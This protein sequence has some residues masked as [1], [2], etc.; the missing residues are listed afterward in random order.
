[1]ITFF[2]CSDFQESAAKC[3][4]FHIMAVGLLAMYAVY[5][6]LGGSLFYSQFAKTIFLNQ[7][8]FLD[9]IKFL[10]VLEMFICI[11]SFTILMRLI[12]LDFSN[13]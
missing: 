6:I 7:K 3:W 11:S 10:G 8:S 9:F 12:L 1:M 2:L 5:A 13:V 4:P